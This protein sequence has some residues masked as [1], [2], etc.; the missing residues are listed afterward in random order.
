MRKVGGVITSLTNFTLKRLIAKDIENGLY[1]HSQIFRFRSLPRLSW[2]ELKVTGVHLLK[3]TSTYELSEYVSASGVSVEVLVE[4]EGSGRIVNLSM[5]D[6]EFGH[7]VLSTGDLRVG[8]Q[9]SEN[10]IISEINETEDLKDF[11]GRGK[12]A[13]T[14]YIFLGNEFHVSG[15]K[16]TSRLKHK[17]TRQL[18]NSEAGE[19][20]AK[21]QSMNV[22][23]KTQAS[24]SVVKPVA[25]AKVI[26]EI[27]S[28]E[29]HRYK[30]E[31]PREHPASPVLVM[32][33][34]YDPRGEPVLIEFAT[35][36][37]L[38]K[39]D[40]HFN[41]YNWTTDDVEKFSCTDRDGQRIFEIKLK[42]SGAVQNPELTPKQILRPVNILITRDQ[43]VMKFEYPDRYLVYQGGDHFGSKLRRTEF[44]RID[45]FRFVVGV[46]TRPL[47]FE[48]GTVSGVKLETYFDPKGLHFP[49]PA[50]YADWEIRHWDEVPQSSRTPA[51]SRVVLDK[52]QVY[53]GP[54]LLQ[55]SSDLRL[56]AALEGKR[57][58]VWNLLNQ[59][60]KPSI[61]QVIDLIGGLP[62]DVDV[63]P[64][65]AYARSISISSI[66]R[67]EIPELI[68]NFE[69][70][71]PNAQWYGLGRDIY[72][73]ADILD[74]HYIFNSQPGR[75]RRLPASAPSFDEYNVA[76][77]IAFLEANGFD[78]KNI[79]PQS[80]PQ[81]IFDVTSYQRT[82]LR[83][84]QSSQLMRAAYRAW[85]DLGRD[86]RALLP[87]V[88]FIG[89]GNFHLDR[90]IKI[91]E[92]TQPHEL[93]S[94]I[95]IDE[96][97]P[98]RIP[99]IEN[100][101]SLQ[102]TSSWHGVYKKFTESSEGAIVA[103]PGEP[104]RLQE[105]L[106]MLW[107]QW[108]VIRTVMNKSFA[109]SVYAPCARSLERKIDD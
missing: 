80:R 69:R 108:E 100:P 31:I 39:N 1:V 18:S 42:P 57:E 2:E 88:N 43:P 49:Q 105:K 90:L 14:L 29:I 71:F 41:G 93:F 101:T 87:K 92:A 89:T 54:S 28:P 50:A 86:P 73:L 51:L 58:Q 68:R 15:S 62:A 102:Y 30:L 53:V 22:I 47:V 25:A 20:I 6:Y 40:A 52:P 27:E 70:L 4:R 60:E 17:S 32:A 65:A 104:S 63:N 95:S 10:I 74:A 76:Q 26:P 8:I 84:S 103:L 79:T 7:S 72:L 59:I 46:P 109:D 19:F 16:S 61:A 106:L 38:I 81:I 94:T 35:R 33:T 91:T 3:G 55:K 24:P 75:V 82:S 37:R 48:Q 9:W 77:V 67:K 12:S 78:F 56:G 34:V 45:E 13:R 97:G 85:T 23:S 21:N 44:A 83:F 64:F 36:Q 98:N 5:T 96:S 107:E 99:Q 11:F 66:I